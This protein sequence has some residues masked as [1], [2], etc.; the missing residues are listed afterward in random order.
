MNKARLD[1]RKRMMNKN[2]K[3]PEYLKTSYEKQRVKRDEYVD[4]RKRI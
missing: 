4:D 3:N 2:A 1:A